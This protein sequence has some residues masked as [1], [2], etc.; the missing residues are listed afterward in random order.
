M[1]L[2]ITLALLL[3]VR[4]SLCGVGF[5]RGSLCSK[6]NGF[7][8]ADSEDYPDQVKARDVYYML[9]VDRIQN[10]NQGNEG[11]FLYRGYP[12]I[13]VAASAEQSQ[14]AL[15]LGFNEPFDDKTTPMLR[16][17]TYPNSIDNAWVPPRASEAQTRQTDG[18]ESVQR[19]V[20]SEKRR[21][22]SATNLLLFDKDN[23]CGLGVYVDEWRAGDLVGQAISRLGFIDNFLKSRLF[24]K[25]DPGESQDPEEPIEVSVSATVKAEMLFEELLKK[26]RFYE[27]YVLPSEGQI[28]AQTLQFTESF[29]SMGRHDETV[30]PRY[31][32][33]WDISTS[34]AKII[35][36]RKFVWSQ[37]G[38]PARPSILPD[39]LH[40]MLHN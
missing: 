3:L 2:N 37:V 1:P 38:S 7:E 28:T 14:P 35:S 30:S 23:K 18:G 19:I 17:T 25:L 6:F 40:Y 16:V 12:S 20:Y 13:F 26:A 29:A 8:K 34:P 4:L 33:V 9:A 10:N 27:E 36:S 39:H 5:S 22:I 31:Q 24:D 32:T 15:W 11:E 21:R